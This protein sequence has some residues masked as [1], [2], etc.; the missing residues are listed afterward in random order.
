ML[1]ALRRLIPARR[2]LSSQASPLVLVDREVVQGGSLSID[3]SKVQCRVNL[4]VTTCWNDRCTISHGNESHGP[5]PQLH[6]EREDEGSVVLTASAAEVD[7][8]GRVF[9]LQA[10][11]PEQFNLRAI[12]PSGH[13]NVINKLKGTTHLATG[14]GN[15]TSGTIRGESISITAGDG[16]VKVRE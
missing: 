8:S 3:C 4:D 6:I 1:V 10:F 2:F 15:I 12:L 13:L 7:L 14:S 9:S 5:K 11:I 16:D